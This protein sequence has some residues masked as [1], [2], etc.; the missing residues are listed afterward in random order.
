MI[1]KCTHIHLGLLG[2][3][4]FL[5]FLLGPVT[6]ASAALVTDFPT[7]TAPATVN[8]SGFA[9]G[10]YLDVYDR[11]AGGTPVCH[12]IYSGGSTGVLETVCSGNGT[13][14]GTAASSY[15][16]VSAQA[17]ACTALTYAACAAG[18]PGMPGAFQADFTITSGGGGGGG[19]A[20]TTTRATSSVEQTQQ[21]L[22]NIAYLFLG[23]LFFT[24][25]LLRS[26]Q[27]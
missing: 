2:F 22:F 21:N 14:D 7:Y 23:V 26:R 4:V 24:V 16:M 10:S 12:L 18:N 13:Y 11:T 6:S 19:G 5:V 8:F 15:S 27:Q 25:W 17:L 20:T 1:K 3:S 9:S